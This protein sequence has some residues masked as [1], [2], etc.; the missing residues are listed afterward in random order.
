ML[1]WYENIHEFPEEENAPLRQIRRC[2]LRSGKADHGLTEAAAHAFARINGWEHRPAGYSFCLHSLS[3]QRR[4]C[5]CIGASPNVFRYA[6]MFVDRTKRPIAIVGQSFNLDRTEIARINND[7][8]LDVHTPP[9]RYA[10]IYYPGACNFILFSRASSKVKWLPEQTEQNGPFALGDWET[11]TFRTFVEQ[12]DNPDD[13]ACSAFVADLKRF[14]GYRRSWT[15]PKEVVSKGHLYSYIYSLTVS[16]FDYDVAT[17][18]WSL[19]E[20]WRQEQVAAILRFDAEILEIGRSL[21]SSSSS[22][23][24]T[25]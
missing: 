8:D 3:D 25:I 2:I 11:P 22:S 14:Y 23:M 5:D 19:F 13:A 4:R 15:P 6:L 10:S 9:A 24:K 7:F 21:D 1:K 20:R 12:Y 18:V 17:T 16:N